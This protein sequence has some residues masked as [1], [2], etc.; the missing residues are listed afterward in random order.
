MPAR[1]LRIVLPCLL[2]SSALAGDVLAP[3]R[4]ASATP[5]GAA[6]NGQSLDPAISAD[7]RYVAFWSLASDLVPNDNNG[8]VDVFLRDD[9]TGT[10]ELISVSTTG[11]SGN[12]P[13]IQPSISADG[14]YVC[15]NSG[16]T[17][18]VSPPSSGLFLIFVRDRLAGTTEV[19]SV[20][21][22]GAPANNTTEFG[23]IS[24]DG[25]FVAFASYADNLVPGDPLNGVR[26]LFLRDRLLDT[27]IL[28][29]Q[30]PLG[31]AS[32][33]NCLSP[34][35]SGDGRYVA[36]TSQASNLV[37]GGT[38]L[39]G[40]HIYLYDRLAGSIALA[41]A[42]PIGNEANG[43]SYDPDISDDGN[44]LA[45]TSEATNL[46]PPP[47]QGGN[48]IVLRHQPSGA[49]ERANVTSTGA[50]LLSGGFPTLSADG[51]FV[52]FFAP[53]ILSGQNGNLAVR[54]RWLDQTI[55][56]CA[57]DDGG[58]LTSVPSGTFAA[59][60]ADGTT[61]AMTVW[62]PLVAADGN[63]TGDI[64][65]R[66]IG[67][68]VR[69]G[70]PKP[71]SLG[72]LP[73]IQFSG[74]ARVSNGY[75]LTVSSTGVLNNKNGLLVHGIAGPAAKPFAGWFLYVE[76]GKRS[77]LLNSAGTAQPAK[78]CSGSWTVDLGNV[79]AGSPIG[80]AA[81]AGSALYLQWWG[82]DPGFNPPDSAQ[83]SDA[84]Q[85]VVGP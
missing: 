78:D 49:L 22:G 33:G 3:S 50:E 85:V 35:V 70:T 64:Y 68:P 75:A 28:V 8:N 15:F 10:V 52:A 25:R 11:E 73:A 67:A 38:T 63:F 83:L 51:R 39:N 29:S 43:Q 69:Y 17:N 4:L 45:F 21:S 44:W 77:M 74:E 57:N 47:N 71:N 79:L 46:L 84:L 48:D 27:T 30:S 40:L 55:E 19:V 56:V 82:R 34:S 5:S 32:N 65:L 7:G 14:R 6:G 12:G 36:F 23:N 1:L 18:L 72:C 60:S 76:Q 59:I 20:S 58:L 2:A 62:A 9:L 66:G 31:A 37:P 13:S 81:V 41:S 26:D 42:D 80:P 53:G 61:V 54:D 24:A 16:T